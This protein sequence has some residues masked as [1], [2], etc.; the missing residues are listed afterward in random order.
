MTFEIFITFT[1]MGYFITLS[2]GI[3]LIR[4]DIDEIKKII[5]EK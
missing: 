2:L 3:M 5:N 4:K 1:T